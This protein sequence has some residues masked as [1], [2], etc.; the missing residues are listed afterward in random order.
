MSIRLKGSPYKLLTL[1]FKIFLV[2]VAMRAVAQRTDD[3]NSAAS[4]RRKAE[5]DD[6]DDTPTTTTA[7]PSS[8]HWN[9]LAETVEVTVLAVAAA[10]EDG[11]FGNCLDDTVDLTRSC[12]ATYATLQVTATPGR[13]GLFYQHLDAVKSLIFAHLVLAVAARR[14]S[15]IHLSLLYLLKSITI[16]NLGVVL[17]RQLVGSESSCLFGPKKRTFSFSTLR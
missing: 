5:D 14:A 12:A 17:I 9:E 11:E 2:C 7:S 15:E 3:L 1:P 13:S 8:L 10:L 6:D 4:P 16:P